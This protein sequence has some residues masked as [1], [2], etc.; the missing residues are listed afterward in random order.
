MN[1]CS[2]LSVSIHGCRRVVETLLAGIR[3]LRLPGC[4]GRNLSI[5]VFRLKK[6]YPGSRNAVYKPVLLCDSA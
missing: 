1:F 5:V 3:P 4:R 2:R 6:I